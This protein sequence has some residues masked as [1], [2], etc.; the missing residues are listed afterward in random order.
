MVGV[1]VLDEE[2]WSLRDS[3]T[4]FDVYENRERAL[5][6]LFRATEV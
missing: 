3:Y 6:R 5:R 1:D 4:F 2:V